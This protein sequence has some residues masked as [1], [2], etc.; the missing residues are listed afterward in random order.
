MNSDVRK[1]IC[2]FL[3]ENYWLLKVGR[4]I[5]SNLVQ[6]P[7]FTNK[8]NNHEK[9]ESINQARGK[10]RIRTKVSFRKRSSLKYTTFQSQTI[11]EVKARIYWITSPCKLNEELKITLKVGVCILDS[12]LGSICG[13]SE[14]LLNIAILYYLMGLMCESKESPVTNGKCNHLLHPHLFILSRVRFQS[15]CGGG[16]RRGGKGRGNI[17]YYNSD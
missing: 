13:I 3:N 15:L 6:L 7:Y 5:G 16:K 9:E 4:E 10:T 11:Q 17:N 8:K 2:N 12:Y 14:K 1:G